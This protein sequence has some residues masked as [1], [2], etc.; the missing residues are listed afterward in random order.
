[1]E[2]KC[3]DSIQLVL[4][5]K[6]SKTQC[7]HRAPKHSRDEHSPTPSAILST[8]VCPWSEAQNA[9]TQGYPQ[10]ESQQPPTAPTR[11]APTPPAAAA[12][13]PVFAAAAA[14]LTVVDGLGRA[15][16]VDPILPTE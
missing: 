4:V 12:A 6:S 9:E 8:Y 11:P 16:R 10:E 15:V 1:M 13:S 7:I 2:C 5:A 14:A 3:G